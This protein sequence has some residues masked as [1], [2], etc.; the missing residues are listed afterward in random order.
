VTLAHT[1][2]SYLNHPTVIVCTRMVYNQNV[3]LKISAA[4]KFFDKNRIQE[5]SSVAEMGDRL[6]TT[7]MSRKLGDAVP[8]SVGELGPHLT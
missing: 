7:D 5:L 8:L 2:D 1:D 3:R 4:A 6:A